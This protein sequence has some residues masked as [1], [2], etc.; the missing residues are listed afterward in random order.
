VL[1]VFFDTA[2]GKDCGKVCRL[3]TDREKWR[4]KKPNNG[5]FP[6][7]WKNWHLYCCILID[8]MFANKM[9]EAS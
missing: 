7:G 3:A 2:S 4:L 6:P 1:P 8:G 5:D 9:T